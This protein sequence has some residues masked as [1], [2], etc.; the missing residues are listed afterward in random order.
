MP[1]KV[2]KVVK[3]NQSKTEIVQYIPN[4]AEA[5]IAKAIEKDVSVETME[6]LLVM[7]TQIKAEMAEEIYFNALSNFQAECPTILK[8]REVR[9]SQS[10]GGG[11][12]YKF[13]SLDDI[14]ETVAPYL[15]NNS[16]SYTIKS[17]MREGFMIATCEA[18]HS[19][20]H[21][22]STSFP[23]PID[24]EAYMNAAQKYKSAD[25]FAKRVAFTNVF[26]I[27][28]GDEDDDAVSTGE[29][30]SPKELYERFKTHMAV[31]WEHRESIE[32]IK[33]GIAEDKLSSAAEAWEELDNDTIM[34]LWLAPTKGGVF[35]THER[36]VIHSDEFS[37]IRKQFIEPEAK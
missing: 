28:T 13:A 3:K 2:K 16:F 22:E 17:E 10:K 31:V 8:K 9:N 32:T 26:G 30:S 5:M 24:D 29:Y 21:S 7:R 25:S 27:M 4:S 35:T 36:T 18:H 6:R 33:S 19:A 20:G 14:V 23:I 11:L 15:K 34:A 12:R 1:K 37:E